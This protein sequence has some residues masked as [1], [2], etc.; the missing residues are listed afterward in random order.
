[1]VSCLVYYGPLSLF[2]SCIPQFANFLINNLCAI[3]FWKWIPDASRTSFWMVRINFTLLSFQESTSH[4][5]HCIEPACTGAQGMAEGPS[6]RKWLL[7]LWEAPVLGWGEGVSLQASTKH[8]YHK[9]FT[10]SCGIFQGF[11]A[12]P[13]KNPDGTMN[14]MNWECA[15][16]GKKGVMCF[17]ACLH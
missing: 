2:N 11:V 4:V 12:V 16:P 17:T 8:R 15:I 14:L 3:R 1:M 9:L 6:F 5:G 10:L 13:T 7:M